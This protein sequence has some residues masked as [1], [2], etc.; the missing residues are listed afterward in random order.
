MS[1]VGLMNYNKHDKMFRYKN[2]RHH[3]VGLLTSS[4]GWRNHFQSGE[5]T[6]A[7]Q[8]SYRRFL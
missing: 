2:Y 6:S 4:R 3:L 1:G 8:K 7:R 5:G